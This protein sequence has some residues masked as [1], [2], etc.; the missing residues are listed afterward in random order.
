LTRGLVPDLKSVR[1]A[2]YLAGLRFEL[3]RLARTCGVSHPA[4]VGVG[5]IEILQERWRSSTLQEIFG[6]EAGWG[7]PTA[8]QMAALS[9][10]MRDRTH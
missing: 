9:L 10:A 7:L 5:Q 6:Y 3:E 8:D 1:C 2:N 4:L